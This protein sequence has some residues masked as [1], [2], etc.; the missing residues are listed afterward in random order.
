[1]QGHEYA[2]V[3]VVV[4]GTE[5]IGRSIVEHLHQCNLKGKQ[6]ETFKIAMCGRH[7]NL[8][9][10]IK[11]SCKSETHEKCCYLFEHVDAL[12]SN[13]VDNFANKVVSTLGMPHFVFNCVGATNRPN[14]F[15]LIP[16]DEFNTVLD[17]NIKGVANSIRSFL[18]HLLKADA[19]THKAVI[20]NFSGHFGRTVSQK[21]SPFVCAKWAIE[22]LSKSVALELLDHKNI[23]CIP[24][25]P[26][27][28]STDMLECCMP[29]ECSHYPKA[30]EWAVKGVPFL[31][32]L[33][34]SKNGQSLT[35][36]GAPAHHYDRLKEKDKKPTWAVG[37]HIAE[38]STIESA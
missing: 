9:N 22:G 23:G 5:G 18:P 27:V 24:V 16:H 4:G 35:A 15:H 28:V 12:D 31:L 37:H 38:Q 1:M 19:N 7:D 10:E 13:A 30:N 25:N 36:P 17:I 3:I 29:E 6:G 33:D 26:G 11:D 20:I 34:P 2:R 21:L 8:L 32:S 14:V